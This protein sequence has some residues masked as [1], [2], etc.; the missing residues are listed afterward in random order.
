MIQNLNNQR[1]FDPT[2]AHNIAVFLNMGVFPYYGRGV[3]YNLEELSIFRIRGGELS[4]FWGRDAGGPPS[5]SGRW[6]SPQGRL[7][8]Y[9]G[10]G[11]WSWPNTEVSAAGQ[12][13]VRVSGRD[14]LAAPGW[15]ADLQPAGGPQAASLPVSGKPELR[16]RGHSGCQCQSL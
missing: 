3:V 8:A 11:A 4:I 12:R 16:L 9:I 6:Q 2:M 1:S 10:P 15:Q 5:H 7:A 14:L 13:T